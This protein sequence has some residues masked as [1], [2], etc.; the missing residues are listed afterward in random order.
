M[1]LKPLE[2]DKDEDY[3]AILIPPEFVEE[4]LV[5]EQIVATLSEEGVSRGSKA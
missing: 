1:S 4:E 5:V 2:R 3:I